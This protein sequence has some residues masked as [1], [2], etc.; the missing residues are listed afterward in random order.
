MAT[1]TR[2]P[3]IIDGR[4]AT[5]TIRCGRTKYSADKQIVYH[6]DGN[7]RQVA[8][9]SLVRARNIHSRK[10]RRC[11]LHHSW[12]D[13]KKFG[14][15]LCEKLDTYSNMQVVERVVSPS[16][17]THKGNHIQGV[18]VVVG[19]TVFGISPEFHPDMN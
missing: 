3:I 11:L 19:C 15:R 16:I 14:T 1:T 5:I 4:C 8:E 10:H 12:V 9:G 2:I 7:N 17:S 18:A 13:D 6:I